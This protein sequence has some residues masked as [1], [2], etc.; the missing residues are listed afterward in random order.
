MSQYGYVVISA[1]LLQ[2]LLCFCW[3]CVDDVLVFTMWTPLTDIINY[4]SLTGYTSL[5][6]ITSSLYN[7][8]GHC[9]TMKLFKS[10]KYWC[11]YWSWSYVMLHNVMCLAHAK[12]T[13]SYNIGFLSGSPM[14]SPCN[15]LEVWINIKILFI[16][17]RRI[18]KSDLMK[19]IPHTNPPANFTV[20]RQT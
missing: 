6:Y 20:I 8:K 17:L 14:S 12:T 2:N 16:N 15:D 4:S 5:W 11:Y 19:Q 10:C 18:Q 13:V 3:Y 9:T 1:V 7:F